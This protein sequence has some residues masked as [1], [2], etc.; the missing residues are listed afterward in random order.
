MATQPDQRLNAEKQEIIDALERNYRR[1]LTKEE[2]HLSLG[3][4]AASRGDHRQRG[5]DQAGR[6][7]IKIAI[8]VEA[9]EA[10]ASTLPLALWSNPDRPCIGRFPAPKIA[11]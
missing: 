6:G 2:I 11:T 10:I 1:P 4:R 8:T 5:A 3:Q 9:F 7:V